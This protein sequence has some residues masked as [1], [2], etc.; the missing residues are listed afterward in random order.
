MRQKKS[1]PII[2]LHG[3]TTDEIFD[4]L[5]QFIRKYKNQEQVTVIVGKGKGIVKNK[6]LEYLKMGHYPWNYENIRG[7]IN[8][9]A[10]IVD[11]Y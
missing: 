11:L 2:D 5:D 1:T 3:H 7:Q 4:L 8:E 10:L 6:V 9:G